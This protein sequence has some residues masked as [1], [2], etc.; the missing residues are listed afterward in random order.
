L[1]SK[2]SRELIL[3]VSINMMALE[4]KSISIAK[5]KQQEKIAIYIQET[6]K[7]CLKHIQMY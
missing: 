3:L 1:F 6:L 2:D 4:D 5:W 7:T